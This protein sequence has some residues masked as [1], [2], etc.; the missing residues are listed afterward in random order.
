M[1]DSTKP[2]ITTSRIAG[3]MN[4]PSTTQAL[5]ALIVMIIVLLFI[6]VYCCWGTF[7]CARQEETP[8]N[9]DEGAAVVREIQGPGGRGNRMVIVPFSN[10]IYVGDPE[11]RRIYEIPVEQDKPPAYTEV[12]DGVPPPPYSTDNQRR[13]TPA[14]VNANNVSNARPSL[15]DLP[16]SYEDCLS[17]IANNKWPEV[18]EALMAQQ[19]KQELEQPSQPQSGS[20]ERLVTQLPALRMPS[21]LLAHNDMFSNQQTVNLRTA[22]DVTSSQGIR[23]TR[24]PQDS[25]V[26]TGFNPSTETEQSTSSVVTD[27]LDPWASSPPFPTSSTWNQNKS[28]ED[29]IPTS[30]PPAYTASPLQYQNSTEDEGSIST[31]IDVDLA[32]SPESESPISDS[33]TLNNNYERN[34]TQS[35]SES[36]HSTKEYSEV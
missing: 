1:D 28:D 7:S 24:E 21:M 22:N 6:L 19:A 33:P 27:L 25:S 2:L 3:A 30:S 16:P 4:Y 9:A 35:S 18:L 15:P 12:Y 34:I 31:S 32:S 5:F 10:M 20:G 26:P 13:N 8:H 23:Q 17:T 14:T 29:G 36:S 11:S